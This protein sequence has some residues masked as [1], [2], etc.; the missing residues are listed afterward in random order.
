M[1]VRE[2]GIEKERER[3]GR[4]WGKIKKKEKREKERRNIERNRNIE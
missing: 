4:K 2:R 3:G 1:C